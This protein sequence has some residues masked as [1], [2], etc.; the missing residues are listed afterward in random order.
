MESEDDVLVCPHATFRNAIE[1]F[2]IEG[3]D[4]CLVAI[5]EFHHISSHQDNKLGNHVGK[6]IE[7]GK[8]HIVAMT[9]SYFRGDAE[10]VL[11]PDDEAKFETFTYTYYEQLNGYDY[12]KTL[13]IGYYFYSGFYSDS[14]IEVLDPNE[15]TIL[16]ILLLK[17]GLFLGFSLKLFDKLNLLSCKE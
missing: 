13:D 15:K 7:R 8:T 6:L 1:R 2:G 9:G 11:A 17:Q 5:D 14:I 12:L 16:H 4:N 10:A 3:L